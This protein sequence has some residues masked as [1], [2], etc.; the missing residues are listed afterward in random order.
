MMMF[1]TTR[2]LWLSALLLVGLPTLAAMSGPV[3]VRRRV[4]LPHLINNNEVAGFKFAT[5]GVLYAVLLAFA[6][7]V[8]WERFD[9]AEAYV[10]QEAGAVVTVYRLS[11]G[12]AGAPGKA[13]HDAT[14]HYLQAAIDSDWPAMER[15][16]ISPAAT[17]ALNELYA[18][19]LAF[20][21]A[22]TRDGALLSE[23]LHQL[24]ALTQNRQ[25]RFV[26]ASGSV[27][28]IVWLVLF[29]GA[30]LTVAF[31]FF[32]GTEN[33]RAQTMMTA[34][35]SILIFS[36]LLIIIAID[37]PFAGAVKI[38]PEPFVTVLHNFGEAP[39]S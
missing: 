16:N 3:F 8:V 18:D 22:D 5:V 37:H 15:G 19:V 11:D 35:L 10:A 26:V 24:D 14:T 33:L 17:A 4:G 6:V 36:G 20:H 12:V 1:L 2:P 7:I 23:L 34:A 31:T 27:P 28:G 30:V 39:H 38:G 29:W 21:P 25:A 13:L 9:Q 32:F